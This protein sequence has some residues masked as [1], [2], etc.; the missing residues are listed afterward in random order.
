[1]EKKFDTLIEDVELANDS[2]VVIMGSKVALKKLNSFSDVT[3]RPA[4]G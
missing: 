3:W 2:P 1:M 4:K